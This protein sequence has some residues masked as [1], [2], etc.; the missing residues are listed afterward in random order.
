VA[1]GILVLAI[2]V[3]VGASL[4]SAA[5]T[6]LADSASIRSAT[7]KTR[8]LEVSA[9]IWAFGMIFVFRHYRRATRTWTEERRGG[10]MLLLVECITGVV[11]IGAS[12]LSPMIDGGLVYS[13]RMIFSGFLLLLILSHVA[14]YALLR[15]I[16]KLKEVCIWSALSIAILVEMVRNA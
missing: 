10:N 12:L 9:L 4:L 5:V 11:S 2:L 13:L 14:T 8:L 6:G 3:A 15:Y 7:G 1:F 16:P